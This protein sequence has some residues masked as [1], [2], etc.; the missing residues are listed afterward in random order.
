MAC[1]A[2]SNPALEQARN[3]SDA[4]RV[5]LAVAA[6]G[7]CEF[8]SCNDFL[9]HD[10][11]TFLEGNFSEMAH[12]VAFKPKGPRGNE[13]K[14]PKN[15]HAVANLMLLCKK[16]HSRIDKRANWKK[17]PRSVLEAWKEQHE[18]R[19]RHLTSLGPEHSTTIVQLKTLVAGQA[20]DIPVEHVHEAIAPRYPS[21]RKGIVIDLSAIPGETDAFYEV[22]SRKVEAEIR[23]LYEPG[24]DVERTKHISLFALAPI[25]LLVHLG[26]TLSNTI[27]V[28]FFQRHRSGAPWKWK[29]TG[30]STAFQSRL[31]RKGAKDRKRVALLLSL[32][33][34][35]APAT[36]PREVTQAFWIYEI[37]TMGRAP[38]VD[39]LEVKASLEAFRVRYR[40]FL[41]LM[42]SEHPKADEL[43]LFPA[44][45]APVA[46]ACGY[47][48]LPK[49]H[50]TLLVYDADRSRGGFTMRKKVNEP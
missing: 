16:C 18:E 14:R 45:P 31:I 43:L 33:G 39:C 11:I 48:V 46:I 27:P 32:S 13:G 1:S 3:V 34:A 49:V 28:D 6:G 20:V 2:Q 10:P 5:L 22:A 21:D 7:R 25:P 23:R 19:V 40:E 24:M 35:I 15:I 44:V 47:D 38:G 37:T 26:R 50:P 36:L 12:I 30:T 42:K 41:G 17:Y 9:F 8:P 4:V 29:E